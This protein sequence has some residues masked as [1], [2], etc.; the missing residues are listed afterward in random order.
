MIIS[1]ERRYFYWVHEVKAAAMLF[2][3]QWLQEFVIAS[4]VGVN[5]G[6][7]ASELGEM[8]NYKDVSGLEDSK[9]EIGSDLKF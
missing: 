4:R 3:K 8:F 2:L 7:P 5:T 9:C 6:D 1:K